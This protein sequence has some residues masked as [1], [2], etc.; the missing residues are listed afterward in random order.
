MYDHEVYFWCARY[1]SLYIPISSI[2]NAFPIF[3][4]SE[5]IDGHYFLNYIRIRSRTNSYN[6]FGCIKQVNLHFNYVESQGYCYLFLFWNKTILYILSYLC[7]LH[8]FVNS[9]LYGC[10]LIKHESLE[11]IQQV[12]INWN[13]FRSHEWHEF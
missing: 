9:R 8:G 13:I 4:F 3:Y 10:R 12:G 6:W 7:V 2:E 5:F 11:C 1:F